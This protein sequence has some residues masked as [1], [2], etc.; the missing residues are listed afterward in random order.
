MSIIIT[1]NAFDFTSGY[2]ICMIE[3]RV[4]AYMGIKRVERRDIVK[5]TG[6]NRHTMYN[7]Y[8]NKT[9]GIDFDTLN[10]LCFALDCTPNDLFRYIPD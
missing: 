7:I 5:L 3:N 4:S 6:I 8:K 2:H 1:N 10:K 9:K